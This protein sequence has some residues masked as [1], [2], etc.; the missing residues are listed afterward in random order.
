[1]WNM[2]APTSYMLHGCEKSHHCNEIWWLVCGCHCHARIQW[3][4]NAKNWSPKFDT[5]FTP[6]RRCPKSP[7]LNNFAFKIS[8]LHQFLQ[9]IFSTRIIPT[10]RHQENHTTDRENPF[11][12]PPVGPSWV[13]AVDPRLVPGSR[14]GSLGKRLKPP[15][16]YDIFRNTKYIRN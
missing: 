12:L 10:P 2:L 9:P 1:M 6:P 3:Y 14:L 8:I 16:S 4:E 15:N 13:P 11:R 7:V 5:K